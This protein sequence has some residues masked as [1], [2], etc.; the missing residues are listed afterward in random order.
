MEKKYDVILFDLDNTLVNDTENH[1]YAFRKMLNYFGI[2][3]S[4]EFFM[5]WLQFDKEYW[6]HTVHQYSVPDEFQH[7]QKLYVQ[8]VRSLR[9]YLFLKQYIKM[10]DALLYNATYI[11]DLKEVV[12]P[13]ANATETL[14]YLS[15]FYSLSI[16]SDGPTDAAIEKLNKANF[17]PFFANVFCADMT[18]NRTY[19]PYADFLQEFEEFA[20]YYNRKKMVI[21]GDLLQKDIQLAM[22]TGIDSVWYNPQA[23]ELPHNYQP[24]HEIHDLL[25]LKRIL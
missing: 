8:Y 14:Q 22:N 7:T 20:G 1:R 15:S 24:T 5:K 16:L 9:Y 21:I 4:E 23:V 2:P 6:I 19:K 13:M 12:V 10:E 18:T 11:N 25:D 17:N 3:Y